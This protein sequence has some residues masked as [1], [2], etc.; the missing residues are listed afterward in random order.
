[1]LA[2]LGFMPVSAAAATTNPYVGSGYDVSFPNCGESAGNAGF[3]IVGVGGGRAFTSNSCAG[4]EWA[5]AIKAGTPVS[6]YYNTGYAPSFA[7]Q[8]IST[9][10]TDVNFAGAFGNLSG[11]RLAQ[12]EQ[13]WEIGCS[14]ASY[15]ASYAASLK[16]SDG[17]PVSWWADVETGNS[18]S[19]N[20]TLNQFTLDGMSYFMNTAT[21][22]IGGGFYSSP[23]MWAKIT[24]VSSGHWDTTPPMSGSWVAGGT[25][26]SLMGGS[27]P[28]LIQTGTSNNIDQDKAC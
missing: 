12:A 8:I 1:M 17:T 19:K 13:A 5:T 25:C 11:H 10:I 2:W 3:A 16:A 26:S 22:A 7:Q 15:A 18:W 21:G 23:S 14:E 27:D 28:W 9:C 20:T 4:S 24:G 6:L